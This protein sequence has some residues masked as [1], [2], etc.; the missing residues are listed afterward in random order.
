[1]GA[2]LVL[3]ASYGATAG[4]DYVRTAYHVFISKSKA[5]AQYLDSL[6]GEA[7]VSD[8]GGYRSNTFY[9]HKDAVAKS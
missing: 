5:G 6:N 3:S 4:E 9:I 1:M 7:K 8:E 2:M